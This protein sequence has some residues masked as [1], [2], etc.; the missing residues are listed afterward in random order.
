MINK[1]SIKGPASY[2][3]MAV[4]ETD[5]NIN[6]I[7][8]LNGSGKSTLSE[9]LR[10]R[11]DNEY[12]ECSISPLLDEDTEEILVYNENYVNDVF[13]SSDTQKGIFSLSKENAGA[14]K[15]IDA[16][17]AALQVANRD[18]QKQELL[19]EKELEA[20][21][22]TKSIFANRFWQ[23]KTQYTGGDRV[24]EY[25][26]TGLKSSKELLL[27]HIVGL[28]KPSNKLVDSIDQLK[29]EIQRLNEAKGTQIPLIQEIT[30][31]A[32]DI[33]IDS[34]FKEVITGNA[35]SRVAKLIDSLHNSDWVKVGLSFDTKD[36]CPFCQ[37]PYLD[38]DII[39]ELRSYF[40]EDYEK[41]V[42]DIESKGKTYK[43][44]IDLIPDIDAFTNIPIIHELEQTFALAFRAYK[45][46]VNS[47]LIEI[48]KKYQN[49]SQIVELENTSTKLGVV[50]SIIQQANAIIV[51]FNKKVVGIDGE[52]A[53]IKKKFWNRLRYDYDQSVTDYNNQKASTENKI[54][55]CE[56]AKQ[57]VQSLIDEQK[58][59]IEAEQQSIVNIE[60]SI[61]HIN[62][63]LVDMGIIDFKIIKCREEGL[64]RIVRGEDRSSVFKTLSEG[65]RTI[66]SVLYF[67]ETCQGIL[68]RSKTQKKRIIV[69]DDPVSSLSTMYVFNIG[70][71]LKNVF[72]PELIKDS[73]Q[74]TGFLMKRKFEQVF[75]LTHNLYFFYEMTDMREP[76]RH[77]YQSLFRV[78]K[79]VAGSKIETMHY[80]HI[81]SDYHTYWMTIKDP[82]THPALIANCMR[83]IIEY[84]FNFVE[85]RDL[86]NVFIQDKFKQ[87]KYQAF[88]RYINRES[89]S[90]GQNINDFKDFDYNIFMD[91][92]KMVFLEMGYSEHYKK[93][94]KLK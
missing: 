84:F 54:R 72:Y 58:A 11:T 30:F 8:G 46:A 10:K 61:N 32:G 64:Y 56:T 6:L 31:S 59:I 69:I 92:L 47:N 67:V 45:E 35:N 70:R 26:F 39:A 18:F 80:E 88:Q 36:I 74:E 5:K 3:N 55:A 13:Y 44:S 4:F 91:G 27:N 73:T 89:H 93:M 19:Q 24:L 42:A 33:E 40:N 52:L 49:P 90:L 62:T 21:T 50:N 2:K 83:N 9:F 81:Q 53:I 37:R 51:E 71:L 34:L 1:I 87:P 17:N 15:R 94:M 20:W 79:S 25:C 16:A 86:N 29:E 38:D 65:E 41:A 43:D 82:D 12:A 22:S 48:R 76:Q 66:I 68:D 57:H 63:M 60:E 78:S 75:I 23:I 7:Y 85:K 14:R 28:A 77:A